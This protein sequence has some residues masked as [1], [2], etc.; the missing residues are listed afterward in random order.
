MEVFATAALTD[1][2]TQRQKLSRRLSHRSVC[3]SVSGTVSCNNTDII[4]HVTTLN[5][6]KKMYIFTPFNTY[7][8]QLQL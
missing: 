8:C 6:S 7:L 4:A 3:L 2:R 1:Y 5:Y